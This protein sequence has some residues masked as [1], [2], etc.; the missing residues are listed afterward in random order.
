VD[1][2]IP[3]S[4]RRMVLLSTTGDLILQRSDPGSDAFMISEGSNHVLVLLLS[5]LQIAAG[6]LVL[7]LAK[8]H[9]RSCESSLFGEVRL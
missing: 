8:L 6:V 5:C 3:L 9:E 4:K 1:Q 2:T 7:L